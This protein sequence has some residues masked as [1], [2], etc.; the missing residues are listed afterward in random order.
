MNGTLRGIGGGTV[1]R[2]ETRAF[3]L[4]EAEERALFIKGAPTTITVPGSVRT[5]AW[6]PLK[7]VGVGMSRLG[8][9]KAVAVGA[10]AFALH[11]LD[12]GSAGR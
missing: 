5:L 11:A 3:N 4:E 12:G 1:P 9:S 6:D 7:R 2:M 10:Y 8:T